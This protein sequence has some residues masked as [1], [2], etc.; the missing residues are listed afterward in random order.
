[1]RP[2]AFNPELPLEEGI[3]FGKHHPCVVFRQRTPYGGVVY[4][5]GIMGQTVYLEDFLP[6]VLNYRA[7][8]FPAASTVLTCCDPAGAHSSSQG[9]KGSGVGVL[10]DHGFRPVWQDG[11]NRP[12]VRVTLMERIAGQMRRRTPMGEAYQ[13]NS[14]PARWLRVMGDGSPAATWH[15]LAD[16]DEAGYVWDEHMVSEGSK[17][18]RRAKKDG[19]YEHGQNAR[20][21]LEL[22]FG[23]GPVVKEEPV[24][25]VPY[26]PVSMWS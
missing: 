19:W 25:Y 18:Y 7:L 9:I 6:I 24:P 22:N 26:V 2:C 3:D 4:L 21:Y 8:W 1:M 17:Q 20:E 11:A 14:D 16:G 23:S 12:S 10:R 13:V 5:G 15:F